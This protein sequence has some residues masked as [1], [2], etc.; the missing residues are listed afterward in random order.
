M[1]EL[2]KEQ[3]RFAAAAREIDPE[4]SPVDVYRTIQREHPKAADLIPEARKNV[5]LIR[6]F[7]IDKKI[8]TVPS[9]VRPLVAETLPPFAPRALL[10]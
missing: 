9:E 1:R 6:Q 4:S 8:V 5:E 3:D 10:K 2:R 7:L